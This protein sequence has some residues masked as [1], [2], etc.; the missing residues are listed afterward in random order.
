[1]NR[2]IS[3]A[4]AEHW[5]LFFLE[6]ALLVILGFVAIW[7]PAVA[8][9]AVDIYIG[10]LLLIGGI[11]GLAAVLTVKHIPAFAWSLVTAALSTIAG[12]LLVWKPAE[13][14]FSLALMLT[15]FFIVEGIFQIVASI[16][17]RELMSRTWGWMLASGI[18]DV[19]LAAVIVL[20]WPLSAAWVL[21]LAVG[22]NLV[23][24][25][26]A[27]VMAALAGREFSGS[28]SRSARRA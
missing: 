5:R 3:R 4:W 20:G 17:Y 8:A 19:L 15:A 28:S 10:C 16:G 27:I 26:I 12:V 23:S 24:S 22:V 13:G 11:A 7:A 25:G 9:I 18:V 14:V 1:M 6:G 2:A 21:G